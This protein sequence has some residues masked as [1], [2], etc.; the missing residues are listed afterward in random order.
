MNYQTF[1]PHPDLAS[2]VAFYWTLEVPKEADPQRQRIIPDGHIEMIFI[3]GDDIKRLTSDGSYVL[4]PRAMILGQRTEPFY[5][6]PTGRVES[7][8]V[9]FY[10]YGFSN[11][12]T[13]PIHQLSNT[14]TP[15]H[16]LL[17]EQATQE[18][19]RTVIAATDTKS[20]IHLV[21]N[22]LL[23]QLQNAA[24]IDKI[25]QS[26]IDVMYSTKGQTPIGTISKKDQAKKKQLERKFKKQV[27]LS[28]K[29]LSKVI[30][31]QAALKMMLGKNTDNLT[32]VAYESGYYDQSHFIRDFKTFT[33]V[34]PN[35]FLDHEQMALSTLFY[36]E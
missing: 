4:Q 12:V 8:A 28:P 19:Q 7:F 22:F 3:I 30:R 18:L 21:E 16:D 5:V 23:Q 24:T 20:R 34:N 27:G 33:G 10:P 2:I 11:F 26:T 29:Q 13:T 17:D 25:V 35:D 36:T 14:E 1:Q 15:L 6:L 31:L 9:S 32:K